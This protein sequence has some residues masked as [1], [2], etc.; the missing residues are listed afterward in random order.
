MVVRVKCKSKWNAVPS[1]PF[2]VL[3]VNRF[4]G[5]GGGLSMDMEM[6]S[7]SFTQRTRRMKTNRQALCL[8]RVRHAHFYDKDFPTKVEHAK[9]GIFQ[10][11]C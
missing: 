1:Q 6:L 2:V 11:K 10:I 8:L 7:S 9:G 3:T 4:V 5:H